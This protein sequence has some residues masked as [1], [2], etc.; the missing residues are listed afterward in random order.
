M[1]EL[2]KQVLGHLAHGVDE[3]VQTAT[4]GHADDDFL[5]AF[6]ASGL[7]Q[8]VHRGNETLSTF[9]GKPLLAHIFSV[10]KTLQAFGSCEPVQD[11]LFLVCREM[12]FAANALELLLPPA[13]L[14]LVGGVHVLGT[15]VAAVGLAQCVQQLA[16]GHGVLAEECVAGVEHGFQVGISEAVE[17]G[18]EFRNVVAFGTLQRVQVGPACA[19]VAVSGNQLLRGDAFA[20][21][22]GVWIG[23][24]D[25]R[26]ALF[27][28]LGKRIDD[29]HVRH[30][31]CIGTV[32]GGHMLQCVEVAAPSVWNATRIGQIV[33]VHL[34]DVRGVAAE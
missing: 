31:A 11:V 14:V 21:H 15:N 17:S 19:D 25:L 10:Q 7:D 22:F 16:Q 28:A 23:Q 3:H 29:R 24:N 9:E 4:V 26:G 8:L 6:G 12:G 2:G 34:F 1:V 20:P 30:I 27:G 5:N 13:L 32:N 33:F 18:F